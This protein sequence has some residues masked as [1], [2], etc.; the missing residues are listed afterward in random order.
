MASGTVLHDLGL[1][2]DDRLSHLTLQ[3]GFNV[4]DDLLSTHANGA[5]ELVPIASKSPDEGVP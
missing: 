2:L 3:I 4:I 5:P 1:L